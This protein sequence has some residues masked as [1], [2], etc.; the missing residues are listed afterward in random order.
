MG[1]NFGKINIKIM[2][3]NN[4]QI[5]NL[6]IANRGISRTDLYKIS[7]IENKREFLTEVNRLEADRQIIKEYDSAIVRVKYSPRVLKVLEY[8]KKYSVRTAEYKINFIPTALLEKQLEYI[9]NGTE[10]E[11]CIEFELQI[12]GLAIKEKHK[13][14]FEN[15]N[16]IT[17]NFDKF[18]YYL[19]AEYL[20][21]F[22]KPLQ[23]KTIN[24]LYVDN[25][26]PFAI[27]FIKNVKREY[28]PNSNWFFF[29]DTAQAILF[30]ENKLEINEV[31]NIILTENN[32]VLNGIEFAEAVREL[33]IEFKERYSDLKIP[34]MAFTKQSEHLQ[35][36]DNGS[37]YES[38]F[39]HFLKSE[40]LYTVGNVIKTIGSGTS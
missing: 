39:L 37:Y 10:P 17:L 38:K 30:L 2:N 27:D 23:E 8:E 25:Y 7:G 31:I 34:I 19:W 1:I 22:Y 11:D 36:N 16:N 28:L 5:V 6:L 40:D 29:T 14:F 35:L 13:S 15:R 33:E 24:I 3:L 26:R 9:N 32:S 20:D 21:P 4:S 18:N 12:A